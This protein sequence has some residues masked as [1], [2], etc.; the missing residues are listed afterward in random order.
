MARAEL[1][2]AATGRV[3]F[4]RPL[5]VRGWSARSRWGFD[6]ALECFWAEL[7]PESGGAPVRIGPEHLVPTV[8]GLAR[9]LGVA[10]ALDGDE[11]YLALTA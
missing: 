8:D 10:V 11:A 2:R 7:W 6:P 9:V 3:P 1:S 4:E 5:V